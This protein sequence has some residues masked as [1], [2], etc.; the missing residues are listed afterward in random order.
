[1]SSLTLAIRFARRE[2]RSGLSGFRIALV[3]LPMTA[4]MIMA[5]VLPRCSFQRL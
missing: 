3:F 2:L 1:M 5:S 4:L